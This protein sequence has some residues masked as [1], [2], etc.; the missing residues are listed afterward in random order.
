[1]AA[2]KVKN[3]SPNARWWVSSELERHAGRH[4]EHADADD[5]AGQTE[6]DGDLW[7]E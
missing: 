6:A 1:M 5:R 4:P 3:Q 7:R 2:N